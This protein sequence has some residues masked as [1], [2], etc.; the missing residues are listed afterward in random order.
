MLQ[1]ACGFLAEGNK[2]M[3]KGVVEK[4]MD[5]I[6]AAQKIIELAEEKQKKVRKSC[7]LFS[8]KRGRLQRNLER[9]HLKN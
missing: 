8:R 2:R 5:E 4:N 1:S 9:K 3:T 7:R 6:E